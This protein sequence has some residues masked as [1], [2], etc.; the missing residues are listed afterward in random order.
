MSKSAPELLPELLSSLNVSV[1]TFEVLMVT[2]RDRGGSA[3]SEE[4]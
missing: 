2:G 3:R 1:P 4:L